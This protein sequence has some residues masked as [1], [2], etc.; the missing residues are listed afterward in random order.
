[1]RRAHVTVEGVVQGVGFRW[2]AARLADRHGVTGWVRNVGGDR[3][4]AELEGASDAVDAVIAWM[5]HGPAGAT[6]DDVWVE[7]LSPEGTQTF[8][9]IASV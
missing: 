5:R 6:V 1:M 9:V 2:S 7:E 8:E 3:V 4:E